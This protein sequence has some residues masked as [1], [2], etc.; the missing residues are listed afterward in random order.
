MSKQVKIE[1]VYN[2]SPMQ[3]GMLYHF[4][5]HENTATYFQQMTFSIE[6]NMDVS[7]FKE[8][9]QRLVQRHEILRT[10]FFYQ[11]IEKPKQVVLTSR[12][13]PVHV[14]D[15]SHLSAEESQSAILS[16]QQE[17]RRQSFDL[18]KDSLMRFAL[19][20][21]GVKE[22]TVVWSF[23]HILL[24]GWSVGNLIRELFAIYSRIQQ[25]QPLRLEEIKPYQAFIEWLEER[26]PIDSLSYWREY[27]A[28]YEERACLPRKQNRL[29]GQEA[30]R[31]CT[32]A[33]S[34]E[35][36]QAL[37]Q[38]SKQHH[39][40]LNT[41]FQ[42]LWAVL[43]QRYANQEDVV[44]GAVHS[45]R[46]AAIDGMEKMVGL[47]INT[48][49][50][51]IKSS[52]GSFAALV[53]TMQKQALQSEMYGHCPLYEVQKQS[54]HKE[55]LFDHLLVFENY[56]LDQ[57]VV[58]LFQSE[59]QEIHIRDVNCFERTNYPLSI[60][61][62]P[63]R[64]IQVKLTYDAAVFEPTWILRIE[65][66]LKQVAQTVLA[67]P[68]ISV[69]QIEIVDEWEKQ[70]LLVTWNDTYAEYPK[71]KTIHRW[72]EEQALK[73]PNRTAVVCK[74][75]NLTYR[76][77]NEQANR[78]AHVLSRSGTRPDERVGLMMERSID[79]I[80][81]I[82]AILKAGGAYVPLDPQYPVERL[83][84]MATDS[85][86]K[87]I[88]SQ[89]GILA[90]LDKA[91]FGSIEWLDVQ[92]VKET[93]GDA[94]NLPPISRSTDLAYVMVTSGTTG[95]PKGVMVEHRSVINFLTHRITQLDIQE[96][97]RIGQFASISFDVSVEEIGMSLLTGAGL[98]LITPELIYDVGKLEDYIQRNRLTVLHLPSSYAKQLSGEVSSSL[99]HLIVGG[100]LAPRSLVERWKER[101][102]HSYGPTETT[103][104]ATMWR[105]D[106]S[107]RDSIVPIGKPNA[108]VQVY[109]VNQHLQLQPV[110]VPGELCIGG[111]GLARGYL[112]QPDLTAET[113]I[114][115]PFV[116]GERLY[117]TGDLVT[118]LPDGNLAFLGRIDQQ[119]KVRG[120]RIEPGE[121]ES[122]LL[123][124]TNVTGATVRD[125]SDEQGE[126]YLAAYVTLDPSVPG[127]ELKEYLSQKLP[128]FM[129]PSFIL[130]L[131]EIPFTSNGK[132]DRSALPKPVESVKGDEYVPPATQ[133]E[134]QLAKIWEDMLGVKPIG[135]T[136]DFFQIGGHSLKAIQLMAIIHKKLEMEVSV[137]ILFDH[138]TI[139]QM[140]VYLQDQNTAAFHSI[141]PVPAQ[142]FY[143][144]SSAQKRMYIL[145]QLDPT[146]TH[147]HMSG[148]LMLEGSLDR[149]R[150]EQ[151]FQA[152][153]RR[154]ESLR[155]SFEVVD[156]EPVQRVH[157]AVDFRLP[158]HQATK[159]KLKH[160]VNQLIQPFSLYQ[161][162]LFRAG[163][164][165]LEPDQ[166]LLLIDLHHIIADGVS[167]DLLLHD[168]SML[169]QGES[170]PELPI[171]YK[172]FSV[173]Q[174]E[175]MKSDACKRQESYW[176]NTFAGEIP[177]LDL[178]TDYVRPER[179]TFKGSHVPFV[180]EQELTQSLKRLAAETETTVYMLLLAAYNV[181]L[182]NYTNQ[183]D[184][185]VASPVVGRPHADVESVVGMFVNTLALRNRPEGQKRWI[186]FIREVKE[187]ALAA[188]DH[189]DY[190]FEVLVEK[191]S[192]QR[193]LGRNPLFQAMITFQSF[194]RDVLQLE[195]M[196]VSAYELDYA[197][198]KFDLLLFATETQN[199]IECRM[200]Y[201]TSL[202]KRET[203]QRMMQH[204]VQIV[205]DMVHHTDKRIAE[206]QMLTD[207][208]KH[209]L[210]VEWND[211]TKV[212]RLKE[213]TIQGL[214]EKQAEQTPHQTAVVFKEKQLTYRELNHQANRLA[215]L[216]RQRGVGPDDRVGLLV[217]RSLEMVVGMLGILKAG[218][219]YVPIDPDYPDDRIQFM[220]SDS[221]AQRVISDD[222]VMNRLKGARG[223]SVQEWID[224]KHVA[225]SDLESS[226]P[227]MIT[228]DRNLA[229][230]IYTSGTTGQPKGVMME[231]RQLLNLLHDQIFHTSIP[232]NGEVLQ[233]HTIS[234]DVSFQEIF[235][236]LISGGCLYVI[237]NQM[238]QDIQSLLRY[239]EEKSISILFWPVSYVK[240]VFQSVDRL[241]PSVQH[242]ITAG[243]QLVVSAPLQ[244]YIR[245]SHVQLHNHY[246]PSETH[247]VTTYTLSSETEREE[248]PPIG[249]PIANT[250]IYLLNENLQ[251]QPQGVVGE[252]YIS[253]ESVARGYLGRPEQTAERFIPHPFI[254]EERMYRTGDLARYRSDGNI[255][256]LGRIDHQ[257]KVRGYRIEPS[258]IESV[259][260][261]HSKVK[262]AVVREWT[263]EQNEVDL[264]AYVVTAGSVTP[265][266]LKSDISQKLPRY[267]LPSFIIQLEEIPLNPNGKVDRSKLPKP[268]VSHVQYE[269][270]APA[271]PLEKQL[272]AI[273]EEVL[274]VDSIGV[275]DDFFA[276]GGH[277]LKAI[278][279]I[280]RIDEV[281]H[282]RVQVS[283]MFTHRT[284]RELAAYLSTSADDSS[285]VPLLNKN[286][287]ANLF[288]FPPIAGYSAVFSRMA[289]ELDT[290]TV[291]GLDF[292][293]DDDRLQKYRDQIIQMQ[294]EGPYRL[295]G[296][297]AGCSL[298]F[299]VAKKMES[300][301]HEVSDLI[302]L[303]GVPRTNIL[304]ST[305]EEVKRQAEE[306]VETFLQHQ[307]RKDLSVGTK[308]A[309][310]EKVENYLRYFNRV[311][312]DGG[313][314][315]SIHVVQSEGG[316][317]KVMD[318]EAMT[319]RF[320][321]YQG[322]G[323]HMDLLVPPHLTTN[324]AMIQQILMNKVEV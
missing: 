239:I 72:F 203:I 179:Q 218:G 2:L 58:H 167:V 279:L 147:Y 166:H 248:H 100:S 252:I 87:R 96:E 277:S 170:L 174:Q 225:C 77:L 50:V 94:A 75:E 16:Y 290:H 306:A 201:A 320:H 80:V 250:K 111:A 194:G 251:L 181:L 98:Y 190:P 64:S 20:K 253:G 138:P 116:P 31:E 200:E 32:F 67:Q 44:F 88:L 95:R 223:P 150:L 144:V 315:A 73:T 289:Q 1:K 34:E 76:E 115:N 299:E 321:H 139:R 105:A 269:Y 210:L 63:G 196:N 243:E 322:S 4:L 287:G 3:E 308:E 42:A 310:L 197:N 309:F 69:Q 164:I 156:G 10:A 113:F 140:A 297:S 244:R 205:R 216:L 284:V 68:E 207:Q 74:E 188:Y 172:D 65:N 90:K 106:D 61:V 175:W 102:I 56:P 43:L 204:F 85:G 55:A 153:I 133:L 283:V 155:T 189:A 86:V 11:K 161:A 262:D 128:A 83:Q 148:G 292:I 235:S 108:N 247:V 132:V 6:G 302:L 17:D 165:Q 141:Q 171:Q 33:I 268:D 231:H 222:A 12:E 103:V 107:R 104:S 324:T 149:V 192:L 145:Q 180:L 101:C 240:T 215:H 187:R 119:V 246:G 178:P 249:K 241:P 209:R 211:T 169:Y 256:F 183:S 193:D 53:R 208:E 263:D 66:H 131:D 271:T 8:S 30:Y 307:L 62:M 314:E 18:Q 137:R 136:D 301:G 264:C 22:V 286:T 305:D 313:V 233:F 110:G 304:F 214:F 21:R 7:A 296:Y 23:H 159:D 234:F 272:T 221:G 298:A 91:P 212:N 259:L 275:T 24:D 266:E 230:V 109:I 258:E 48:V 274:G 99:R 54:V 213:K 316:S 25:N 220:L 177:V 224:V 15:L 81:G 89:P 317:E 237:E 280:S 182:H 123:M 92:A 13:V 318:W 291:V 130:E 295:L 265:D 52:S 41:T 70:Q 152:L 146:S 270:V 226:N 162:P 93:G 47:F 255:E 195:G 199:R 173:W 84:M 229:Y 245:Q 40:T 38:F 35:M 118:Y 261:E 206:V 257:V 27:L 184:V 228:S 254:P 29:E 127:H 114:S 97:D 198:S 28:G 117:R 293:E 288:C 124:H 60:A 311:I 126:S 9:I 300:E 236:T 191:L 176:L 78:L 71:E 82:L 278:S 142:A 157:A 294:K 273:W 46:S 120:Y 59:G 227:P 158:V 303:D 260:L 26:D 39:V 217:E 242:V 238:K 143:P 267:M 121:I 154:H 323:G 151:A 319:P 45:G 14:K 285:A 129:I 134:K 5:L 312:N 163:L 79:G 49:P 168:L 281:L 282:R 202:F 135:V 51:R 112:G 232:F 36:T 186:D 19:F 276:I 125:W 57:E 219:A 185:I 122:V 160:Q 37:I